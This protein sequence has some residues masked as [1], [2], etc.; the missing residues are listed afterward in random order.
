MS[1]ARV[2]VCIPV[3]DGERHLG[4]ALASALAQDVD[5]LEVLVHDDASQDATAEVVAGFADPRVRYARH[6][7]P[8]GVAANRTSLVRAARGAVV[9][10]L[11]ADDVRLPGTL[12]RQLAVLDARPDVVLVHGGFDVV[13]EDGRPLPAW[14]A[15]FADDVVEP[16][17]VAFEHLVAANELTTSTV[18]ARRGALLD[19]GP[20]A[21]LASSSDW[22]MW[23]RLALRGAI[24]YVAAPVAAYRQHDASVSRATTAVGERLRC[25]VRLLQRLLRDERPLI[26][27][28]WR[29]ERLARAALAAQ[30][31]LHAGDA[32]TRGDEDAA[33]DALALAACLT[34]GGDLAALGGAV[35]RGD[36]AACM[37]LTRA[38]LGRLAEVLDGTRHGAR[39]RELSRGDAAWDAQLER[40]GAAAARVTPADAVIAAIAKWD[41][42]V[43]DRSGRDGCNFPDRA[44]LPDGYPRDGVAAVAHLDALRAG[45]GVTH[46]VVPA[47]S[48]WWLTHYPELAHR[49]GAPLHRDGDCAIYAV[50]AVA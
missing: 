25:N 47:A 38:V 28:P 36:D 31:V 14:P 1:A 39:V 41:P 34:P 30:A 6:D 48:D 24:A 18:V 10:W 13:D 8:V 49:L 33:L 43:L 9:A 42:T 5:G 35:G 20:F 40:A 4:A 17:E 11:D 46:V 22:D 44:L 3:R 29:A 19:A 50:G 12:A 37:R 32:Y 21:A 2:S 26:A 27:D 7:E 15:P 16:P 45:R 23:L